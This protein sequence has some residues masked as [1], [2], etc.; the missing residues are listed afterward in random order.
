MHNSWV[1]FALSALLLIPSGALG[2][3]A[4][5]VDRGDLSDFRQQSEYGELEGQEV[6]AAKAGEP[7]LSFSAGGM[8]LLDTNP[9]WASDGSATALLGAPSFGM[10]YFHPSVVRGWDLELTASS[11]ADI[12]SHDAGEFNE[13]RVN[14]GVMLFHTFPSMGTLSIG[15]RARGVF[16]GKG[17]GDFDHS[18]GRFT[19]GFVPEISKSF[20]VS[21]TGE[22]RTSPSESE[23]RFIES[24]NLN[25]P[26]LTARDVEVSFLQE[27]AFSQF[28]AG[29]NNGRN[30]LLSLSEITLTPKFDLPQG[31]R[32]RIAA[33]FF[34]RFSNRQASRFTGFQVGPTIGFRF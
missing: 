2:Q 28:T 22:Y 12:F 27:L 33:I 1:P 10:T 32:F 5:H 8:L 24:V 17:F 3:T 20:D 34:H 15:A 29:S 7:A 30:D 9:A 14:G 11:D 16:I 13:T 25:L 6:T 21:F 23:R 26:V 4:D 18:L 31:I 19:M